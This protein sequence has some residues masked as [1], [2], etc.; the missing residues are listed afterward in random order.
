MN[1]FNKEPIV[2]EAANFIISNKN[3]VTKSQ[4]EISQK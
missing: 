2:M 1:G 3:I 4:Y